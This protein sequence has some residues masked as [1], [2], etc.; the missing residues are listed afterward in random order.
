[1]TTTVGVG[2][3]RATS[4]LTSGELKPVVALGR[5]A[6]R[7]IAPS[8]QPPRRSTSAFPSG[9]VGVATAFA[10]GATTGSR[11]LRRTLWVIALVVAYARLFT[12][13]HYPS[14]VV[15]GAVV[16]VVV[17][18]LVGAVASRVRSS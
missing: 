13:R 7:R 16:G 8:R 15:T 12:G 3:T 17:G 9:H 4:V 2:I 6:R 1:M 18:R 14:D 11:R 5:P 10:A